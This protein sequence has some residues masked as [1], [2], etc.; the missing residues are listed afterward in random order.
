MKIKELDKKKIVPKKDN[1]NRLMRHFNEQILV[2]RSLVNNI[3]LNDQ[4]SSI[5][6]LEKSL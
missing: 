3:L 5:G 4:M 2:F 6:K 1:L